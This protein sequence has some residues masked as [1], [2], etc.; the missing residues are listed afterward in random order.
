MQPKGPNHI[1]STTN[2]RFIQLSLVPLSLKMLLM[3]SLTFSQ[4]TVVVKNWPRTSV[5]ALAPAISAAMA[6]H[7][8]YG[9]AI[10]VDC[11]PLLPVDGF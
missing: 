7:A 5:T 11:D 1:H 2:A 4:L 3:H 9:T 6:V 10:F 8:F